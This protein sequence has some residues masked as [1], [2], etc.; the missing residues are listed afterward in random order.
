MYRGRGRG[1][2]SIMGRDKGET[3]DRIAAGKGKGSIMGK[4]EG[5]TTDTIVEG[6]GE[7]TDTIAAANGPPRALQPTS[8]AR[9]LAPTS[10]AHGRRMQHVAKAMAK[11]AA[12]VTPKAVPHKAYLDY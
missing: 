4:D 3:R 11:R 12:N 9:A 10:K 1:K 8:K 5:E 6:E 2:G 7:A